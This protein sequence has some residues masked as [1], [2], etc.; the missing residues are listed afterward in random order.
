MLDI[1]DKGW[2][3]DE[4]T[5]AAPPCRGASLGASLG[6]AGGGVS[7]GTSGSHTGSGGGT[8]ALWKSR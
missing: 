5:H 7:H 1:A 4:Q 8:V 2:R 3:F 6:A